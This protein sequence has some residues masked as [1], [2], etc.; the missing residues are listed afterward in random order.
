MFIVRIFGIFQELE[1]WQ[2]FGYDTSGGVSPFQINKLL[3]TIL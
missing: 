1:D 3:R 2:T